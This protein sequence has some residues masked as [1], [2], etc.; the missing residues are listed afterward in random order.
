MLLEEVLIQSHFQLKVFRLPGG[1]F[2]CYHKLHRDFKPVFE[3]LMFFLPPI[4][5]S[6]NLTYIEPTGKIL[7]KA[8]LKGSNRMDVLG[9]ARFT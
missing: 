2:L 9:G 1:L 5:T 3:R 7:Q 4:P 8:T 6:R